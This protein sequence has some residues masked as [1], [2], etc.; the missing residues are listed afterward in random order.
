MRRGAR[1]NTN[2]GG[3]ALLFLRA[4]HIVVLVEQDAQI[5]IR[6]GG[7]AECCHAKRRELESKNVVAFQGGTLQFGL[8]LFA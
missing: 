3:T 5:L 1:A 4:D 8:H 7:K 2:G 6:A